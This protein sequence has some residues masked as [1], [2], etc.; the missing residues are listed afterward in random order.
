MKLT[1]DISV[2]A[3]AIAFYGSTAHKDPVVS[4]RLS[5]SLMKFI[6]D[7]F[8]KQLQLELSRDIHIMREFLQE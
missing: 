7:T 3:R 1:S 4:G 6:I 8:A 5:L 2:F